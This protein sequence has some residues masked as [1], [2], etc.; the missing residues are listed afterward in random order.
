MYAE[1]NVAYSF[2]APKGG[3]QK[4]MLQ[5]SFSVN[6]MQRVGLRHLGGD[7]FDG[8]VPREFGHA[9]GQDRTF[10]CRPHEAPTDRV[11][12]HPV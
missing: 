9:G 12:H 4:V 11:H 7:H 3:S 6:L 8:L 1:I 5:E 2:S 10:R